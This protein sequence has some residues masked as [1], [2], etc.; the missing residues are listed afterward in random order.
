LTR[1]N[2][3]CRPK[4]QGGL[5]IEVLD[6]KNKYLLSKWLF[7]VLNEEAMWQELLRNKYLHTHTLSQ[8]QV[9]PIDSPFQKR[10]RD[11]FSQRG[12]FI[13]GDGKGTRFWEDTWLGDSS[14]STQYLSFV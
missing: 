9:K 4:D 8:V 1:W 10:E 13:V 11:D 2:I 7:K 6:I 12:S 14:L 5:G 3:I